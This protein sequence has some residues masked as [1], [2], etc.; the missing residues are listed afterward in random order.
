MRASGA[1]AVVVLVC[2]LT[3]AGKSA[4]VARRAVACKAAC[5][6]KPTPFSFEETDNI[7][8]AVQRLDVLTTVTTC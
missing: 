5:N 7:R 2:L 8:T 1:L 4:A 3:H 6:R